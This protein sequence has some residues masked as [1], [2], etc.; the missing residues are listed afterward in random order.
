MWSLN[1]FSRYAFKLILNG[2]DY[3]KMI[4]VDHKV[5]INNLDSTESI[6]MVGP[7]QNRVKKFKCM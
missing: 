1:L 3:F 2:E 4:E 5:I 6:N 7:Q